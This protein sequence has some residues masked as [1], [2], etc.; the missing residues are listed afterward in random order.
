MSSGHG[1]RDERLAHLVCVSCGHQLD[2]ALDASDGDNTPS[3]GAVSVCIACGGIAIFASQDD[4]TFQLRGLS[5]QERMSLIAQSP[6]LRRLLAIRAR[7][8][9]ETID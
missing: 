6:D 3:D 9:G 1:K 2:S 8:M 5:P 7:I 4:G